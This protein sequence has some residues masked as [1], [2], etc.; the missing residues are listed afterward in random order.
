M[1]VQDVYKLHSIEFDDASSPTTFAFGSMANGSMPTDSEVVREQNAG[2]IFPSHSHVAFR[3]A[4]IN[5]TTWNIG[6]ALWKLGTEGICIATATGPPA[7]RGVSVYVARYTCNSIAASGHVRY[8]A[9]K[10]LVHPTTLSVDHQ[11]NCQLGIMVVGVSEDGVNEP[12]IKEE[13]VTLPDLTASYDISGQ[14]HNEAARWTMD[15]TTVRGIALLQKKSINIEWGAQVQSEGADSEGFDTWS[16]LNSM[17]PTIRFVGIDPHWW[18]AA[19]PGPAGPVDNLGGSRAL[20]A[21]TSLYF[22]KREVTPATTEHVLISAGGTL[23]MDDAF[24]V[25][26][27][28]VGRSNMRLDTIEDGANKPLAITVNTAIP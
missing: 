3:A 4:N 18:R 5:L 24:N 8:T 10:G 28:D 2:R 21:N 19:S 1:A 23:M 6:T 13:G 17:L 12:L 9:P 7:K 25:T 16:S 26:G 27:N 14:A 11:G 15:Q 22:R 20:H